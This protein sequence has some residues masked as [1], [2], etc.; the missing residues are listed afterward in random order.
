MTQRDAGPDDPTIRMNSGERRRDSRE[1]RLE[2]E[3]VDAVRVDSEDIEALEDRQTLELREEELIAHK[4]SVESG[5]VRLRKVVESVPSRLEVEAQRDELEVEHIPMGQVVAERAQAREEGGM[6]I[7]PV[8]E[9]QLVVVKRLILREELHVRRIPVR[10]QRLIEDTVMR[11]R[12]EIDE[13][14]NA[15]RVREQYPTE[16]EEETSKPSLLERMGR[17]VLE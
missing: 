8:Y 15:G 14:E 13:A 1:R 11:E 6:W 4:E 5:S 3:D 2:S 16:T 9:E 17:K 10:E 12:V 7:I